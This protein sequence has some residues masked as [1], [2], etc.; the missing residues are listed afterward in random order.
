VPVEGVPALVPGSVGSK[1]TQVVVEEYHGTRVEDPYRW[2]E[3][4]D[5]ETVRGW[6]DEQN[7]ATRSVLDALP[8]RDRLRSTFLRLLEMG[9]ISLPAIRL[10][11]TGCERFFY[12]RRRSGYEQSTLYVRDSDSANER[13]LIDTNRVGVDSTASIAWT[14]ASTDGSLLAWGRSDRGSED[15]TLRIRAVDSGLELADKIPFTRFASLAWLPHNR[16][17]FYTRYP[18]PGTVP[19]AE[20]HYHRKVYLHRLGDDPATDELVFPHPD[21]DQVIAPT[22]A[23]SVALSPNGRWLIVRVH[24][25]AE[26]SAV[27]FRDLWRDDVEW[28]PVAP[29]VDAVFRALTRDDALYLVTN[30]GAPR[31][32]LCAVDYEYPNRFHEIIPETRDVLR[33]VSIIGD[34]V[35]AN[36]LHDAA[37]RLERFSVTGRHLGSIDLPSIGMASVTGRQEGSEAY[38]RF[39]SFGVPAEILRVNL[40]TSESTTWYQCG[41]AAKTEVRISRLEAT[42][43]DGTRV[44]IF[45]V[46]QQNVVKD[47]SSAAVLWGYGGFNQPASPAY[48]PCALAAVE[49][50]AVWAVA[51]LRGGGE[52]GAEWHRAGMRDK[53]QNVFDDFIACAEELAKAGWTSPDRLA[54]AGSSNGGLLTAAVITQRPDLVRAALCDVPLTDMLRYQYFRSGRLWAR[55]YGVSENPSEFEWLYA[56]SPYHRLQADTDYPS[57]LFVAAENDSRVDPMH[58]CKMAARM[59]EYQRASAQNRRIFLRLE[60][61]AGHGAGKPLSKLADELTDE[62]IFLFDA[63]GVEC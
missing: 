57:T 3:A 43:K 37:T 6:V 26:W 42:S 14:K 25:S 45:L 16:A 10:T 12:L 18:Q 4:G 13:P 23:P 58:A 61:D 8:G 52:F 9:S 38:V 54:I 1:P 2:L 30:C 41:S 49:H 60:R 19:E 11:N 32:R 48:S 62:M 36:Y 29:G 34:V 27:Y 31:S 44:P 39:T 51:V 63:I 33:S 47:G 5:S 17:F 21:H 56:Y 24:R 20:E 46:H 15:S 50:G 55:E 22:D 53:K 28:I 7:R 59:Q 35:V 40:D